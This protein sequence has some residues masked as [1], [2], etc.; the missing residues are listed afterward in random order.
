MNNERIYKQLIER[1]KSENRVKSNEIYY[2]NHHIIPKCKNGGDEELNLVLLTAR[3]HFLA[4]WLLVKI[5]NY[6][7]KLI[8]AFN[9]FCRDSTRHGKRCTSRLYKY[10]RELYIK[11]LKENDEWKRKVS[12]TMKTLVWIKNIETKECIRITEDTVREFLD[13][14]WQRGRIIEHRVSPTQQTKDKISLGNKGK[15]HTEEQR[16]IN[17]LATKDRIWINNG[18]KDRMMKNCEVIPDGWVKGRINIEN[19]GNPNIGL[20]VINK[21]DKNIYVDKKDLNMYLKDGWIL[22]SKMKGRIKHTQEQIDYMKELISNSKWMTNGIEVNRVNVNNV[23][24]Y[25]AKGWKLGR[26][27]K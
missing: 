25:E 19:C 14:G 17:G 2:E 10:A 4:H 8:Y 18:I 16:R 21:L 20:V 13:I 12:N 7:G 11:Y 26:K 24:E 3:E 9:S 22:G 27:F 15:I 1:A 23:S 5:Y 6:D